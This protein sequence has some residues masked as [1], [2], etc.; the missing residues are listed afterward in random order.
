[1]TF[2]GTDNSNE[3]FFNTIYLAANVQMHNKYV[4]RRGNML[5]EN[6]GCLTKII[7]M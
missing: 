7:S 2:K 3:Q 4:C 6:K 5:S 1:M